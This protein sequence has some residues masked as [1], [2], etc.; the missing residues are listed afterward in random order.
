MT[1]RTCQAYSVPCGQQ[2]LS[3]PI[4]CSAKPSRPNAN[5]SN[6]R[7]HVG[8][9]WAGGRGSDA[10]EPRLVGLGT[11]IGGRVECIVT[12]LGGWRGY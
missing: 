1:F 7:C 9:P 6:H 10:S 12:Y 3:R 5:L 11:L 8:Q 2:D 4:V